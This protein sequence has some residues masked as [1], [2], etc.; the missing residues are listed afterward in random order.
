M[1][2]TNRSKVWK[3]RWKHVN[4]LVWAKRFFLRTFRA[5]LAQILEAIIHR[6]VFRI[7]RFSYVA[8][9]VSKKER[10]AER[11]TF[12]TIEKPRTTVV[13]E[14]IWLADARRH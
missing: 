6:T 13:E 2:H 12:R 9:T 8:L 14:K 5:S 3:H 11:N 4:T 7:R 10:Q 1:G